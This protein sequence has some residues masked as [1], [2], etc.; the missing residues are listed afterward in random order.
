VGTVKDIPH[1]NWDTL[2]DLWLN[3]IPGGL[4]PPTASVESLLK[5]SASE[6]KDKSELDLVA[7]VRERTFGDA[8]FL[9]DKALYCYSA[10]AALN[11]AGYSTW[12]LLSM[13]DA[14]FFSAKAFIYLLGFRDVGRSSKL[15]LNIFHNYKQRKSSNFDGHYSL[16]LQERLTHDSLWGVFV[17]LV[18]T[19]KGEADAVTVVKQL[20]KND[21]SQFTRER[22]K[23]VYESDSW[24]R[25]S[26]IDQSDL[27]RRLSYTLNVGF[28]QSSGN[29]EAEYTDKYYRTAHTL[30]NVIDDIL[31]GLSV[32]APAVRGYLD[33]R[34]GLEKVSRTAFA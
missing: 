25:M 12:T 27:Q 18:D 7:G 2:Q 21:Y 6:P 34:P 3:H 30:I 26:L 31:G 29:I 28:M 20:R 11:S 32:Y 22:N 14:C 10:S 17:R 24:S 19:L 15:Y 4:I 8:I 33:E 9:R 5:L 23:L 13:Y 1:P 16:H